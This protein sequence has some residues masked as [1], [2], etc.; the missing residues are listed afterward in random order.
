MQARGEV[1]VNPHS[2]FLNCIFFNRFMLLFLCFLIS[3][4]RTS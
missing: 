3:M 4:T 1:D 2:L